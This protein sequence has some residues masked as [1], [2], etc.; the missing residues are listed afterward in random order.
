VRVTVDIRQ[1]DRLTDAAE[2]EF[3]SAPV[4]LLQTLRRHALEERQTHLYKNQTGHLEQST[5]AGLISE[6]ADEIVVDYEMGE[7]YASFVVKRGYSDFPATAKAAEK[8][9][10]K[11]FKAG[12]RRL[13]RM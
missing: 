9:L 11:T 13:S 5:F 3:E 1:V 4:V 10:D 8:A 12:E 2:A 7:Q 6:T